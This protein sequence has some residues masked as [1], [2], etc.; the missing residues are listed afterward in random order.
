MMKEKDGNNCVPPLCTPRAI[1]DLQ[2]YFIDLD[3]TYGKSR[4]NIVI[5]PMYIQTRCA[6]YDCVLRRF[7]NSFR[8]VRITC[9]KK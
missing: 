3:T 5:F 7:T 1:I 8:C 6:E 4:P 2:V 9:K